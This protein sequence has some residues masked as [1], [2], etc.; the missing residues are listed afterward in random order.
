MLVPQGLYVPVDATSLREPVRRPHP[1]EIVSEIREASQKPMTNM[2]VRNDL[3]IDDN[4]PV[5]GYMLYI[6]FSFSRMP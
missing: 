5:S 3:R 4:M 2:A 1:S 6:K